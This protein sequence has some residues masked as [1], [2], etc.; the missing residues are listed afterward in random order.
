MIRDLGLTD[1]L[2]GTAKNDDI[3]PDDLPVVGTY[4][5]VNTE[6]LLSVEPTH[7]LMMVSKSGPPQRIK[8][9]ARDGL[10]ELVA[11]RYP[12]QLEDVGW[13]LHHQ[14][15]QPRPGQEGGPPPPPGLGQ[16]LNRSAKA[17]ALKKT[18]NRQLAQL[19][20]LTRDWPKPEVLLAIGTNPLVVTGPGTVNHQLLNHVGALNVA[21]DASTTA[22][23]F[24]REALLAHQPEV[25][26]LLDPAGPALQSD[27]S[28]L[29]AFADLAI[30]AVRNERIHLLNAPHILLPSTNLP[31]TAAA[32]ARAIHPSRAERIDRVMQTTGDD[33]GSA[34]SSP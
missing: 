28:R 16:V 3:A 8:E 2:V 9:L 19:K 12:R 11:Y 20:A 15:G 30:P 33:A 24:N 4:T 31:Q 18:V 14:P 29:A 7:V 6:A 17:R 32:L 25:I 13:I 5:S 21:R 27:D 1:R 10:F 23:S 26:I 22:P 34:S